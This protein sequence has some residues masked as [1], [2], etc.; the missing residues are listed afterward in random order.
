MNIEL[1][2][3][4]KGYFEHHS[5]N[6]VYKIVHAFVTKMINK[7]GYGFYSEDIYCDKKGNSY[8][9]ELESYS[10][11]MCSNIEVHVCQYDYMDNFQKKERICLYDK[12]NDPWDGLLATE[13]YSE[14]ELNNLPNDT[15]NRLANDIMISDI[16]DIIMFSID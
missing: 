11:S 16:T 13:M 7:Y 14:S 5:Y 6:D 12:C 1:E 15:Y 4:L 3:A 8:T 9:I 10:N 2:K